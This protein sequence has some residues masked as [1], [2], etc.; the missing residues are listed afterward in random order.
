[1][2]SVNVTCSDVLLFV[3]MFFFSGG[4]K[5]SHFFS[6]DRGDYRFLEMLRKKQCMSRIDRGRFNRDLALRKSHTENLVRQCGES[7]LQR[8]LIRAPPRF[9]HSILGTIFEVVSLI[10][11]SHRSRLYRVDTAE[12][13]AS[14]VGT[15][16]ASGNS[17]LRADCC[18]PLSARPRYFPTPN[19]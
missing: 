8:T 17:I 4:E 1:M 13:S 15:L 2:L 9:P 19:R 11:I 6:P 14:E 16:C 7:R 3:A 10:L 12:I 18:G 5:C